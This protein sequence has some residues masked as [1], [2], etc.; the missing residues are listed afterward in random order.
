[1]VVRIVHFTEEDNFMATPALSTNEIADAMKTLNGWELDG[2]MITKTYKFD[3]YLS[4][5]AFAAAV[6]TVA[7]GLDHH[8]DLFIGWRKVK[9]S[10]T[11]HDAGN[12]ISHKDVGA[13][14][15]VDKLG[16]PK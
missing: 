15:A 10:F 5:V 16:Y 9:V 4:G 13:A 12:K 8:P 7:E 3:N 6:G 11:T 14:Q 1:M 2:D